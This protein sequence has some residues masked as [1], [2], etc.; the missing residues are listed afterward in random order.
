MMPLLG[1]AGTRQRCGPQRRSLLS[2]CII[3]VMNSVLSGASLIS[4]NKVREE[5]ERIGKSG[6]PQ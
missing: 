2:G 5:S 1:A 4:K 6:G 3:N